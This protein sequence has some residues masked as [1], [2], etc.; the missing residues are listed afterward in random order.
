MKKTTISRRSF[1]KA[2]GLAA[3]AASLALTGCS[4]EG[5]SSAA[6][7]GAA[8]GAVYKVGIVNY[9]DDASLNQIVA[10]LEARL[11]E[12]G[13]ERGVTFNYADYYANAQADQSNLN[14]IGADLVADGV[15]HRGGG[16]PLRLHHAGRCGGYRHPGH[17]LGGDRPGG[18]RL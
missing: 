14:Q 17:L 11:D 5:A 2:A 18:G 16:H 10:S 8:G 3:A 9:V 4:S 1:L 7:S 15:R 12:A 6:G 13:A